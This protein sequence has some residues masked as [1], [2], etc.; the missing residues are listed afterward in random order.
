VEQLSFNFNKNPVGGT[1]PV[2]LKKT[3]AKP[4]RSH[5]LLWGNVDTEQVKETRLS[6]SL[7]LWLKVALE[8]AIH[9]FKLTN[10]CP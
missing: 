10:C 4:D 8:K 6:L 5:T 7:S 2:S 3:P 9:Q 1:P